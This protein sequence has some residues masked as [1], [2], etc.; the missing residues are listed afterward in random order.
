MST[1]IDFTFSYWI[2]AWFILYQLNI[3][4]YNPKIFLILAGIENLTI[5]FMMIYYKNKIKYILI[6]IFINFFIKIIPIII[7]WNSP[8]DIHD[9]YAGIIVLLMYFGWLYLNNIDLK[10]Q[11]T[12][13]DTW[14]RIKQNKT[15]S[16]IMNKIFN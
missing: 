10:V 9:F 2:F 12:Q 6:F 7:L 11:I 5:L 15:F 16:P 4:K 1:R 3:I 13:S 14:N 8:N